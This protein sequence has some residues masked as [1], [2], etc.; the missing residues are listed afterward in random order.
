MIKGAWRGLT[1][2][3][4]AELTLLWLQRGENEIRP[5]RKMEVEHACLVAIFINYK[6]AKRC[7]FSSDLFKLIPSTFSEGNIPK[8]LRNAATYYSSNKQLSRE[9]N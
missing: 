8:D 9:P 3:V 4:D 6:F 2:V 7:W 1:G 5:S